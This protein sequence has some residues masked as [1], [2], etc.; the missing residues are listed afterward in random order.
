MRR[1]FRNRYRI[2]TIRHRGWD[3]SGPGVY[4]ITICTRYGA[5]H[6]GKIRDGIM[7][8]SEIG[9]IANQ[10]WADIPN[11][12]PFVRLGEFVIM[13]N[14]VHGILFVDKTGERGGDPQWNVERH[15]VDPQ[16]NIAQRGVDPHLI[17]AQRPVDPQD[18]ADLP[19]VPDPRPHPHRHPHDPRPLNRFGPQSRNLASVVRGYKIGVTKFARRQTTN[20]E[21]QALFYDIIIRNDRAFRIITNYIRN[22]PKNWKK[23]RFRK[24]VRTR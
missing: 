2:D 16:L 4:F 8:H 23:D 9:A 7:H 24:R 22:N 6:F 1:L 19:H 14:H 18:L 13:P 10:C 5:Y 3:Y 11:H 20:F 21:W 12:F 15:G 17:I